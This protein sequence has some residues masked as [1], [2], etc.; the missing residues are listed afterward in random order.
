MESNQSRLF[1]M[2]VVEWWTQPTQRQTFPALL[3][4]AVD[5]LSAFAMSVESERTFS[6]AMRTT[7]W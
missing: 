6:K 2:S 1:L 5:L 4:L 7:L 3:Q